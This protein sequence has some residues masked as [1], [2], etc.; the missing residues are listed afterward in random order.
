MGRTDARN[1]VDIIFNIILSS[2]NKTLELNS[3]YIIIINNQF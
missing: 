2:L 3:Y 1:G